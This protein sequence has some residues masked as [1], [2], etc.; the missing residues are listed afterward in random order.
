MSIKRSEQFAV[1]DTAPLFK[2]MVNLAVKYEAVSGLGSNAMISF[3]VN[4]PT[5]I[6]IYM[7]GDV[8]AKH[9]CVLE[10]SRGNLMYGTSAMYYSTVLGD[11]D[12]ASSFQGF[13]NCT[14]MLSHDPRER[15]I[16]CMRLQRFS[17]SVRNDAE[18]AAGVQ[19]L[20][21]PT[22]TRLLININ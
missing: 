17:T 8:L 18:N 3:M 13:A 21:P 10:K 7:L 1:V 6:E 11:G 9:T 15:T 12:G 5:F 20:L 19:W 4:I 2:L 22:S 14:A 16:I